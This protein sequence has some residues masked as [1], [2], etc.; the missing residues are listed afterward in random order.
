ML[1]M[2][3]YTGDTILYKTERSSCPYRDYI[4]GGRK[5]KIKKSKICNVLAGAKRSVGNDTTWKREEGMP[6]CGG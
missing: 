2:V 4:P 5:F 1:V 6:G 3:L